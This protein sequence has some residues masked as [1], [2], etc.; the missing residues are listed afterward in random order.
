MAALPAL[1]K[2]YASLRNSEFPDSTDANARWRSY[3]WLLKEM[4][5]GERLNG[6]TQGGTRTTASKWAVV[7]SCIYNGVSREVD[8]SDL[9]GTTYDASKFPLVDSGNGP[10]WIILQNT[11]LG[12]QFLISL[13]SNVPEYIRLAIA[14]IAT[15]FSGGS[16]S[17]SP[18]SSAEVCAANNSQGSSVKS[19]IMPPITNT[20]GSHRMHITTN[21]TDGQFWLMTSAPGSGMFQSF[22]GVVRTTN[23][24]VADTR[25]VF[26]VWHSYASAPGALWSWTDSN[27]TVKG[28]VPSGAVMTSGG[29]GPAPQYGSSSYPGTTDTFTGKYSSYQIEIMSLTPQLAYRGT[30]PDLIGTGSVGVGNCVPSA[31]ALE[32]IV[33]GRVLVPF[34]G[35]API[36]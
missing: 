18:T 21:A 28:L 23:A 33:V 6:G 36:I 24:D 27:D 31:A 17:N 26:I 30:V 12:Y 35:D 25:N 10:A 11:A 22:L 3:G 1:T 19:Y 5:V 9:W 20:S 15:P 32:R 7:Q 14:P 29:F 4:L 16:I 34:V 2:T 8:S 13:S